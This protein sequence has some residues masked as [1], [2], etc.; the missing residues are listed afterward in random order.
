MPRAQTY[1]LLATGNSEVVRSAAWSDPRQARLVL[2]LDLPLSIGL[3]SSMLWITCVIKGLR[4]PPEADTYT[5]DI[6]HHQTWTTW[7]KNYNGHAVLGADIPTHARDQIAPPDLDA[8]LDQHPT[9]ADDAPEFQCTICGRVKADCL[10]LAKNRAGFGMHVGRK[11]GVQSELSIRTV[12]SLC[13][14]CTVDLGRR[15]RVDHYK[16]SVRCK[17]F[18]LVHVTPLSDVQGK[19]STLFSIAWRADEL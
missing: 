2:S 16:S 5:L 15:A 19:A 12:L 7:V 13:P 9:A 8:P 17:E 14:C 18:T 10:S 11:H 6:S 3:P 4:E 1:A